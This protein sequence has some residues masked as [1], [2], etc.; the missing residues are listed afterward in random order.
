[1]HTCESVASRVAD[2]L[3]RIRRSAAQSDPAAV[4]VTVVCLPR[5]GY[6]TTR[7]N[8]E[9]L[10]ATTHTPFQLFHLDIHSPP[11]VREYLAEQARAR[12]GFHHL[13]LDEYVS[14][15]TARRLVLPLVRTPW[16]VFVDN[17]VLFDDGWLEH[18]IAATEE[19]ASVVSPLIVMQGG[20]VHFSGS[21]IRTRAD[22]TIARRQN[23]DGVSVGSPVDEVEGQIGKADIDFGESHCC[24]VATESFADII[25]DVF[26]E[27]MHNAH[28]LGLATYLLKHAHGH[29]MRV[30]PRSRVSILPIGFGYDVP[31]LFGSYLDLACLRQAY[32]LYG[33]VVGT[34]EPGRTVNLGW[35]RKHLLYL[36]LSMAQDDRLTRTDLLEPREVPDYVDGY[37]RPLPD[38]ALDV[39]AEK[40]TPFVDTHHP[41]FAGDLAR[42]LDWGLLTPALGA[43]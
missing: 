38:D 11:A 28:T 33:T 7:V 40:V 29:A 43:A 6:A 21:S 12:P 35:H 3:D 26:P 39:I 19:P 42:W 9:S 14:R 17:N 15:Q 5:H 10:Y 25:P 31:W 30:E 4:P 36:L 8:V 23:Q 37:D 20:R 13:R 18:L 1:M 24:L 34:R 16:T 2:Q 27:A 41:R 32:E 22:G